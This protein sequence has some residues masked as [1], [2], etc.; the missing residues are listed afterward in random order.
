MNSNIIIILLI[1]MILYKFLNLNEKYLTI[2][3]HMPIKK[4]IKYNITTNKNQK[5]EVASYEDTVNDEDLENIIKESYAFN[6]MAENLFIPESSSNINLHQETD[7]NKLLKNCDGVAIKDV[8]DKLTKITFKNLD[9]KDR[10][11]ST[12]VQ[13][14]TKN[15]TGLSSFTID[16]VRYKNESSLTTGK[17]KGTNVRAKDP[18]DQ[19]VEAVKDYYESK[20]LPLIYT[21]Y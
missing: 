19:K 16:Q 20:A 5:Y 3:K 7:I 2:Q 4:N 15:H 13:V 6:D 1:A 11:D 8:Y 10:L 21:P 18:F 12:P 9:K 14:T 17:F